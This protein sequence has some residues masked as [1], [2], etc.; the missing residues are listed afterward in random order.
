MRRCTLLAF[1]LA[2][3]MLFWIGGCSGSGMNSPLT[4]EGD[5]SPDLPK[6]E[7]K[8][9][10]PA[11]PIEPVEK[12]SNSD[13]EGLSGRVPLG[14]YTFVADPDAG[15][16]D[17]EP[18]RIAEKHMNV[19][20][21]LEEGTAANVQLAGPP[22]FSNG[23][24]QLDVDIKITHPKPGL[25]FT[26]F[27][28]RGILITKGSWTGWSDPTLVLSGPD[29]TRLMNPDGMTRWWNPREF[30]NPGLYGYVPGELGGFIPANEAANLNGF[31]TFADGLGALSGLDELDPNFRGMF[32]AGTSVVRHYTISLMGGLNFN[33]AVDASWAF[34]TSIPPTP[35]DD[36]PS[37]ANTQEPY[38]VQ[39]DEWV[40]TLWY[41][42]WEGYGGNVFYYITIHDWQGA[43]SIGPAKIE[44]PALGISEDLWDVVDE[45]DNFIKYEQ[46]VIMP[47][48]ASNDPIDVL[49][50]VDSKEGNYQ[51]PLTGVNK[52]LRAYQLHSTPVSD[53]K[54]LFNIK[55]IAIMY[56]TTP[57]DILKGETVTF[58]ASDSYD[59]DGQVVGYK[60][61]FNNDGYFG[62]AYSSGTDAKPTKLFG[63]FGNFF[64]KVQIE[65]NNG[66]KVTSVA[67]QVN[68]TDVG[69]LNPFA[70]AHATT[71]TT[72][73]SDET[74]AFDASESYD[75]DGEISTYEWDFNG[76]GVYGDPFVDGDE[77]YPI[78]SWPAGEYDVDLKV[79]DNDGGAGTLVEPIHVS[80]GNYPPE[81]YA[82]PTTSTDILTGETVSFDA[83]ASFDIDG[84][85]VD[86]L[87]DFDGDDVYG[88]SYDGDP[89]TPTKL[90]TE[91][92]TY[93]VNLRVV[94]NLGA[95]DTLEI[96][97]TVDVTNLPPV[98]D[99]VAVTSTNITKNG[100]VEFD[101]SASY[102]PNGTI[103]DYQWDFDGDGTFGD[104]PEQGTDTNPIKTYA[105]AGIF[106]V[107]L[108]VVDNNNDTDELDAPIVVTVSNQPPTA[109]AEFLT[110]PPYYINVYYD[111]SAAGS[112]DPDGTIEAYEWDLNY[113]GSFDPTEFGESIQ[114]YWDAEGDYDI[115]LRVVDDDD[116]E[117]FLDTPIHITVEYTDN[118]PPV[119]DSI[120]MSRTTT[121]MGESS[122][123]I[124]LTCYGHDPNVGD[125]LTYEWSGPGQFNVTDE[126][127][128]VWT[129][130]DT[131]GKVT[132]TCR[133]YDPFYAWDEGD[134]PEIRVTKYPTNLAPPAPLGYSWSLEGLLD[135][136]TYKL[137]DYAGQVVMINFWIPT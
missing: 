61:D 59:T 73:M 97:I 8:N 116:A 96:P 85:I 21:M 46:R 63:Q 20:P 33:Y 89:E 93:E 42:E 15:T 16:L 81:A 88:D 128:V 26:G 130:P 51:T 102:D 64:I 78:V 37:A 105:S 104:V 100:S 132:V 125:T 7:V 103:V 137:S 115:M 76:D 34:P 17:I 99:A 1:L 98:A 60:W 84:E 3:V 68:V 38:W 22:K 126:Q 39:I 40:N 57:T 87:W 79:I 25:L 12:S 108:R 83:T 67:V 133:V 80:V 118:L 56:A 43:N 71:P 45:G 95:E 109:E 55:P 29:E 10:G 110:P 114:A 72:I 30:T 18:F 58:D 113:D 121:M 31:K 134:S 86:Y 47:I 19:V 44:I 92:G 129:S 11:I 36:F 123:A 70:I 53:E 35:P 94:D 6:P 77:I 120:E 117:D 13:S 107:N 90:Y 127:T 131:V 135:T 124:T 75:I 111:L 106:N 5:T 119:F 14:F 82:E 74:V 49:V 112:S 23:G 101:A 54:Q 136:N 50:S 48:L 91:V 2:F 32:T 27:D 9:V 69:N 4:P 28:A 66:A 41:K 24:K 122:E 65:D 52:P 62:D